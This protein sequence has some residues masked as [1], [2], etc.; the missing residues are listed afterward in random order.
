[1]TAR[2]L[3]IVSVAY[4]FAPV[5]DDPVGGAEQVLSKLDR[6]IVER[7][8]RSV[9][10]AQVG[11]Y[12]AGELSTMTS[13][14]GEITDAARAAAHRQARKRLAEVIDKERPDLI[15]FH[16][17]DF[18]SYLPPPGLTCLI[19]LHL[20]LS[21]YKP[22]ALRPERPDTWLVPVSLS[23]SRSA[24]S[25]VKL[26]D[27][28][29]NG[30]PI[31]DRPQP[32]ADFALTIGRVCIEKGTH[33]ALDAARTAGLKLLVAGEVF[34][35]PE[36]RRYWR[37]AVRPRLDRTRRWIGRVAGRRKQTLLGRAKCVLIPSRAPET[38][39][40]VAMEALAA[41]TP[42]IAYPS[43][44]LPEIV[45]HGRSGFIVSDA[46]GMVSAIKSVDNLDPEICRARARE[47]FP[48]KRMTDRYLE[49]YATLA[50]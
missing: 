22:A 29:E 19:S 36:H 38:S 8:H 37:E 49:Q 16:G 9:V 44:A 10:I 42:V 6:A 26:L 23:Q 18:A 11:S 39:S 3:T 50:G 21:W 45:E 41:G 34:P 43:G 5:T 40:L 15:H 24:A 30:V 35:Y 1:M 25:D 7:G 46:T 13:V 17:C 2:P 14:E 31:P 4:P 28:I 12:V 27:P 33:E 32:K 20:P 47:R 48:L